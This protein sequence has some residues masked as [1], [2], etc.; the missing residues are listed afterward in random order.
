MRLY[1]KNKPLPKSRDDNKPLPK[2]G[3]CAA[4]KRARADRDQIGTPD[5]ARASTDA[6]GASCAGG[7]AVGGGAA[8]AVAWLDAPSQGVGEKRK[9]VDAEFPAFGDDDLWP[10]MS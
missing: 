6:G 10:T 4:R 1:V 3:D 8:S 2:L 7:S 9:F 5:R